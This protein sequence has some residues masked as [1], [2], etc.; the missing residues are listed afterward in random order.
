MMFTAGEGVE[1]GQTG[2]AA[3]TIEE[4]CDPGNSE[5]YISLGLGGNLKLASDR[6][7]V[8]CKIT[9]DEYVG[10]TTEAYSVALCDASGAD[11]LPGASFDMGG[12][13]EYT[14]EAA[15]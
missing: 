4:M 8:G 10:S 6:D 15:E 5:H 14:P 12:L 3:L 2:E 13:G 11:C 1:E 9:V 7:L